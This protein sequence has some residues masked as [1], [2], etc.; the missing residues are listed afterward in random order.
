M[1]RKKRPLSRHSGILRDASLIVI[2]SED[3]HAVSGYFSRFRTRR[4]QF[5]VL[6]TLDGLSA[7]EHVQ[8]RIDEFKKEH[9]IQEED[10]FWLCIDQDHWAD[11][12]HVKNLSQVIAH[13]HQ[14]QYGV[15][16][17]NPCF[18]LWLLLHF[19]PAPPTG[20]LTFDSLRARIMEIVGGYNKAHC[21]GSLP[22][23]SGMVHDAINR[24]EAMDDNA[25]IPSCPLTRVYLILR[26]LL[27]RDLIDFV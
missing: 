24:A 12:G 3:T 4:V 27:T 11:A 16:I 25:P 15:A 8:A 1:P 20:P 9:E 7:P 26:V 10:Q 19:E 2:A 17:S 13:C 14:R 18:E 23:T 5:L 21:C 22:F 6:P